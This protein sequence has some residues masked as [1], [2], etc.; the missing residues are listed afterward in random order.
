MVVNETNIELGTLDSVS[1]TDVEVNIH[2]SGSALTN[3]TI[4]PMFSP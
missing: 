3:W 1:W 4:V 2:Y